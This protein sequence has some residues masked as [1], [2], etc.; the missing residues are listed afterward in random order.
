MAGIDLNTV[1]EDEAEAE[2]PPVA[3]RASGAVCLE[4]WHACVGPITP[5]PRKGSAILY[6]SQ[7]HLEHIGGDAE[8]RAWVREDEDAGR[9]GEDGAAMK[10]LTR[11]PHM[12]C[13]TLTAF[14]TSTHGG[15]SVPRCAAEDCFPSLV[16]PVALKEVLLLMVVSRLLGL[17]TLFGTPVWCGVQ[18]YNQQRPLVVFI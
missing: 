12:F 5:L 7:G 3:A 16:R 8:R 18:D 10:P 1:E 11:K 14:D 9:D 13:K 6:L 17:L 2:A 15:F 4:L